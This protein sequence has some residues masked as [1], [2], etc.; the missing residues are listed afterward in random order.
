MRNLSNNITINP[1]LFSLD[2]TFNSTIV[3]GHV[4]SKYPRRAAMRQQI[5]LLLPVVISRILHATVQQKPSAVG[6]E[7]R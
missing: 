2:N 5:I 6:R 3:I 1:P 4:S 7:L